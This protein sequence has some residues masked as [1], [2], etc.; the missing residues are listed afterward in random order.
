MRFLPIKERRQQW[1]RISTIVR[2]D[3]MSLA[4]RVF[5]LNFAKT[6]PGH[7]DL[8]TPPPQWLC[9]VITHNLLVWCFISAERFGT[10]LR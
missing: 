1:W 6:V 8:A 7:L 10:V 2:N 4:V 3:G 5:P 9:I